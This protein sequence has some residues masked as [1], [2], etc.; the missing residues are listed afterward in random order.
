M[1]LYFVRHGETDW[2]LESKIQGRNDIPLNTTG[3]S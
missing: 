2:N 1:K 3:I